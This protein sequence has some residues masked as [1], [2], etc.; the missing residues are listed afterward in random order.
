MPL[1]R[2]VTTHSNQVQQVS[3]TVSKHLMVLKDGRLKW[4]WKAI[5]TVNTRNFR[6][7][8]TRHVVHYIIR[9]HF[10]GAFYAEVSTSTEFLDIADFLYRAW[11]AKKAS[12]FSGIPRGLT[13]AATVMEMFPGMPNLLRHYGIVLIKATS[14]FQSGVRDIRTWE[15]AVRC[16]FWERS[17]VELR[18]AAPALSYQ[19]CDDRIGRD[20]SKWKIWRANLEDSLV[21]ATYDEFMTAYRNGGDS[22]DGT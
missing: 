13:V 2:Y 20:I 10:S 6:D 16:R 12:S 18:E 14:G 11:T 21:P 7:S 19:L 15:E 5:D 4:Q 17:Y 3:V 9:D 8:R 22:D 1:H